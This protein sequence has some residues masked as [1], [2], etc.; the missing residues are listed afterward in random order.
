MSKF[1]KKSK[2]IYLIPNIAK[3]VIVSPE[4]LIHNNWTCNRGVID[5]R[6]GKDDKVVTMTVEEELENNEESLQE[7]TE[8]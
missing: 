8:N 2:K 3:L 7:N 4:N 6:L 1:R 5:I